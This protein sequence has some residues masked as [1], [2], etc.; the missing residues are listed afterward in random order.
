MILN[1]FIR[2]PH[3]RAGVYTCPFGRS[4]ILNKRSSYKLI[5]NA[6]P[7]HIGKWIG[8]VAMKYFN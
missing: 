5:G 8:D 7:V 1:F 4:F 2:I 6:V 3:F